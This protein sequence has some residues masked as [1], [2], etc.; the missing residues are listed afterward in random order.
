MIT[1]EQMP[2]NP[3]QLQPNA[4]NPNA[5]SNMNAIQGVYGT[6]VPNTFNRNVSPMDQSVGQMPST[7]QT[8][9]VPQYQQQGQAVPT[10]F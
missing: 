10:T 9:V 6:Q 5:F 4:I 1:S 7:M 8:G 2:I 3:N